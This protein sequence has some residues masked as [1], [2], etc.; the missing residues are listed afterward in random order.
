[1]V[2]GRSVDR[3]ESSGDGGCADAEHARD[4]RDARLSLRSAYE[5]VRE[6]KSQG[7]KI[8]KGLHTR[9]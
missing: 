5:P 1:V 2:L 6:A 4:R 7:V 8:V 9:L 3:S